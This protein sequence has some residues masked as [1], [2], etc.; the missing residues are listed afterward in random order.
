MC[1]MSIERIIPFVFL[2]LFSHVMRS[3]FCYHLFLLPSIHLFAFSLSPWSCIHPT[4]FARSLSK[5][6]NALH[7]HTFS[8]RRINIYVDSI[9]A[10]FFPFHTLLV[11]LPLSQMFIANR[12]IK[13]YFSQ[14]GERLRIIQAWRV[15][16]HAFILFV[17]SAGV[18][19]YAKCSL[20]PSRL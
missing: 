11:I 2:W 20:Y 13:S 9:V 19:I 14:T 12:F 3:F 8:E 4:F 7:T 17:Y 16:C 5:R 1:T 6:I 10:D 15:H 18:Y